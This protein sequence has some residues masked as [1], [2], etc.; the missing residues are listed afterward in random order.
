MA[1]YIY[2]KFNAAKHLGFVRIGGCGLANCLFTYAHAIAKARET[3]SQIISPTWFNLSI[4]TYLRREADKR[5][6]LGLFTSAGEISGITKYL[7]LLFCKKDIEEEKGL[8]PY[9]ANIIENAEYVSQ[10]IIDHIASV[11]KKPVDSYDFSH[12]VAVHVRLGDFD[13]ECRVPIRWYKDRIMEKKQEGWNRFLLFSD[14]KDEELKELM[15]IEGVQRVFFGSAISD[16]YAIS[17][18]SYVLGSDS[19]FSGWGIYL[20]QVPCRFYRKH[21]GR[22]LKDKTKE[23]VDSTENVWLK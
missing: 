16:I 9:F 21:Y 3:G 1:K 14:G 12:A 18:C 5:H 8:D 20:G 11:C 2:P 13:E 15:E 10:Y 17:K 7:K 19:T 4:G 23:I 6:Y 22:L